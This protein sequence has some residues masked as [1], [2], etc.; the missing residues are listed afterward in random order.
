MLESEN[1]NKKLTNQLEKLDLNYEEGI[2]KIK[3]SKEKDYL[4]F[5]N[6]DIIYK[7]YCGETIIDEIMN[8]MKEELSEPYPIFTYRYFLNGWPDLNIMVYD[9][10]NNKF[11]GCIIGKCDKNKKG[12][13]KGYIAMIAVNKLYR[14]KRIGKFIG[15]I[16]ISQCR[17]LYNADEI[18]LETEVTN[19]AALNLYG[20]LGFVR[21]KIL[22]NYYLNNNNAY[23]LKLW[24]VDYVKKEN[25]NN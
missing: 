9:K 4:L 6:D 11:I 8:L 23:R 3:N 2:L 10:K 25:E 1:A 7:T 16:F 13:M 24:F 15:E 22:Y 20:G 18:E 21:T 14:G 19:I 5:E 17:K 12:K